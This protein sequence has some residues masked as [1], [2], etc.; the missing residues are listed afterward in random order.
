MA[1]RPQTRYHEQEKELRQAFGDP[2]S[3]SGAGGEA[4][5]TRRTAYPGARAGDQPWGRAGRASSRSVG[6]TRAGKG[7][8]K[9]IIS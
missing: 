5:L 8:L 6:D 1:I 7:N 3:R 4:G 9:K 2:D